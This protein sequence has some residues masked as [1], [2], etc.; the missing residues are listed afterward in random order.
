M[1]YIAW[2]KDFERPIDVDCVERSLRNVAPDVRRSRF[3]SEGNG[4]RGY[5]NGTEVI[6]FNYAD[7]A[8]RGHVSLEIATLPA[9]NTRYWH[10][11]AK[12]GN[13]VPDKDRARVIPLLN[14]ANRAVARDCALNF[15]ESGPR[16][17]NE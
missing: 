15:D 14:R 4:A 9:G 8:Q 13:G 10:G 6:Q 17:W 11:W 7:P 12:L 3:V 1:E 5:P 16:E 2:K